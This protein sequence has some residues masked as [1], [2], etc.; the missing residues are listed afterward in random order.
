[1]RLHENQ[2]GANDSRSSVITWKSVHAK[3]GRRF[4]R[5]SVT[6]VWYELWRWVQRTYGW[7][8]QSPRA[9]AMPDAQ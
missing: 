4:A 8:S 2:S 6:E 3:G 9:L 7:W 1:M 5:K